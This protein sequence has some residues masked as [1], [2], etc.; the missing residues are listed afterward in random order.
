MAD[1]LAGMTLV[2]AAFGI[3]AAAAG[4]LLCWLKL[5]PRIRRLYH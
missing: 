4:L 5:V 1:L 2:I 3:V